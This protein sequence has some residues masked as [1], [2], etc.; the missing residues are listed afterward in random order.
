MICPNENC[1][2][3]SSEQGVKIHFGKEHEGSLSKTETTCEWCGETFTTR[4]CKLSNGR[5]RFCGKE[6]MDLWQ[7]ETRSG[8]NSPSY[9]ANLHDNR[10][11]KSCGSEFT[12]YI[13][14]DQQFCSQDCYGKWLSVNNT[15]ENNPNWRGGVGVDWRTDKKW[16]KLRELAIQRD[17]NECQ[18]CHE[19]PDTPH[20]HHITPVHAG[21]EKYNPDNLA[22]LC[23][24]CH[25]ETHK[26]LNY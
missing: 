24:D 9:N 5:G 18:S 11:C 10:P 16:R 13:P 15:G 12:A 1:D 21:G 26:A 4:K 8:E 23:P 25:Y 7:A 19:E 17:G 20:V 2:Y 14:H 6:C 3:E 22:T